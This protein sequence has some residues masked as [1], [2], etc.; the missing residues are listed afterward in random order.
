MAVVYCAVMAQV[1]ILPEDETQA[2]DLFNTIDD[3]KVGAS[4][5]LAGRPHNLRRIPRLFGGSVAAGSGPVRCR[6]GE[7]IHVT[8]DIWK[9]AAE[10]APGLTV[11]K[12]TD[13][14]RLFE[15]VV[16]KKSEKSAT[17]EELKNAKDA[18]GLSDAELDEF[19]REFM[20]KGQPR[21]TE[22]EFENCLAVTEKKLLD[23]FLGGGEGVKEERT[24]EMKPPTSSE[25]VEERSVYGYALMLE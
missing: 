5:A 22:D 1:E 19:F 18:F 15:S 2:K 23:L 8:L 13:L 14:R 11:E 6:G 21:V 4:R 9:P 16:G 3:N 7:G 24:F 17:F 10:P 12:L 25:I 20:A